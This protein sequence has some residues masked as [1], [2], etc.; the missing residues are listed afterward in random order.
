MYIGHGRNQLFD[1]SVV[2]RRTQKSILVFVILAAGAWTLVFTARTAT[3]TV[4]ASTV[5]GTNPRLDQGY[6]I[7]HL[8]RTPKDAALVQ[9]L[10]TK[11]SRGLWTPKDWS[12][13]PGTYNFNNNDLFALNN[14]TLDQLTSLGITPVFTIL[15]SPK[16]NA[17][18]SYSG[19]T[20]AE[21]DPP[22]DFNAYEQMVI[23]GLKYEKTR[24]PNFAYLEVWNEPDGTWARKVTIPIAEYSKMYHYTTLAVKAVNALGLPGSKIKIGGPSSY[25]LDASYIGTFLDNAKVNGDPVDFVSWHDY[26]HA[27]NPSGMQSGVETVQSMLASRG[28]SAQ[29]IITEWNYSSTPTRKAAT[30]ANTA[31]GAAFAAVGNYYFMKGGLTH[32]MYFALYGDTQDA[33]LNYYYGP[34]GTPYAQYNVFKMMSMQKSD[35]VSASTDSQGSSGTGV[36]VEAT[37]DSTGVAV[38]VWNYQSG[39]TKSVTLN[40]NSLPSIFSGQAIHVQQYLVDSTHSNYLYNGD[41]ALDKVADFTS[42]PASSFANTIALTNNAVALFVLTPTGGS[43]SVFPSPRPKSYKQQ[44]SIS[45]HKN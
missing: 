10:G 44:V 17:D 38:L 31:Q 45:L 12:I 35:L 19:G 2:K 18:T 37:Q 13:G 7:G 32:G 42:P 5:I 25:Y 26:G 33:M 29:T 30:A 40:V 20:Y 27:N 1:F 6:V 8:I 24:Y 15:T 41:K 4:T 28:M 21:Q 23:D 3:I 39:G 43:T 11:Y 36:G 22:K 16:W 14:T 9:A 34:D